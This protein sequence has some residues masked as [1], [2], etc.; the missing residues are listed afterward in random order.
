MSKARARKPKLEMR[1]LAELLPYP[2]QQYYFGDIDPHRLQ[3]LADD[4]RAQ[5]LRCPIE[6]L[7]RN[8]AG[9]PA[10]TILCG[11]QR[12]RALQLNGESQTRVLVRYDFADADAPTIKEH[13]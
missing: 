8:R 2:E 4:I 6:V 9:L 10:N 12:R 11:H 3:S 7:P 1:T 13:F 5:G